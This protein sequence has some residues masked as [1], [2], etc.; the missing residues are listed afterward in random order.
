MIAS[1]QMQQTLFLDK[2]MKDFMQDF[3]SQKRKKN[4]I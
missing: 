2:N 1:L 4:Y 3:I